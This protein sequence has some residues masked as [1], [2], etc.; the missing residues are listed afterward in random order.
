MNFTR[1]SFLQSAFGAAAFASLSG[2]AGCASLCCGEKTQ[3]ALQLYS[4]RGLM[5]DKESFRK[6]LKA[7]SD[8]GYAGVEFAGYGGYSAAD[9]KLMLD[10]LGLK[11]A[12][13][14]LGYGSLKPA[15]I[16]KTIDFNL[17]YGNH[18]LVVPWMNAP[19]DCKDKVGF[20]KKFAEG[21]SV[22]AETAK[23]SGCYVG[24]HN[25]QHELREKID[26]VT[27]LEIIFDNASPN[28]CLQPDVGH[29][30][31][32]DVD[33]VAWL[34]KYGNRVR[35]IHAK[36]VYGKGGATG[37]LGQPGTAKGVDWPALYKATDAL[38]TKWYIVECES[39]SNT[40]DHVKSSFEFLHAAGR[41]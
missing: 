41:C 37:V 8:I 5:K 17:E 35:T 28:L 26:G 25:H 19:K 36:E 4:I 6:T 32:A 7:V 29:F 27:L 10:D 22:A 23:K 40:I 21:L 39:N 15:E 34:K 12:G 11:R 31:S 30:V 24:Y 38:K 9:L 20:W 33:P 13:T 3:V 16:Q 18:D 1:R 14:H 2:T